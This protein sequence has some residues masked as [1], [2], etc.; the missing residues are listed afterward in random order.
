MASSAIAPGVSTLSPAVLVVDRGRFSRGQERIA[1]LGRV[2]SFADGQSRRA[3]AIVDTG[4]FSSGQETAPADAS[5]GRE[6]S[7]ADG[8][9]RV[10]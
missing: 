8:M 3:A 5:R 4:R 2:G 9:L 1:S 6:G 7:Y 10:V